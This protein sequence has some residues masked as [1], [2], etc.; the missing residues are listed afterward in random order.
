MTD[1]SIVIFFFYTELNIT[2]NIFITLVHDTFTYWW[3]GSI[4][5][6][7]NNFLV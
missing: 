2:Y 4:S 6:F 1:T 3:E 7:N 5:P